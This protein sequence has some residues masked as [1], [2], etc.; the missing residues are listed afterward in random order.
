MELET[1]NL[2]Y[3]AMDA[4][5]I[6]ILKDPERQWAERHGGWVLSICLHVILFALLF[7]HVTPRPLPT[8]PSERFRVVLAEP[9]PAPTPEIVPEVEITPAQPAAARATRAEAQERVGPEAQSQ[10]P[11]R[12]GQTSA[13]AS[14]RLDSTAEREGARPGSEGDAA[15]ESRLLQPLIDVAPADDR[16]AYLKGSDL[17]AQ[18]LRLAQTDLTAQKTLFSSRGADSGAV[19]ELD[20]SD[21][22]PP[23]AQQVMDRYGIQIMIGHVDRPIEPGYNYLSS[24]KTPEG[25]F[26]SMSGSGIFRIFTFGQPAVARMAQLEDDALRRGGYTPASGRVV[27][28]VF[29]IVSTTNG[30]DLGVKEFKAEP[31]PAK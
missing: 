25:R 4:G 6:P 21:V 15:G 9:T 20:I 17:V 3:A 28:I 30:Y 29:G 14:V 24:A 13:A 2:E 10:Q 8:T 1:R 7:A 26:V 16:D 5:A 31:V 22:A 18:R 27:R 23:I 12:P 11:A 19:R